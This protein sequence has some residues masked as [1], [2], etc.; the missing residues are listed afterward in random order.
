[1]SDPWDEPFDASVFDDSY[2]TSRIIAA[3]EGMDI[4]SFPWNHP[5]VKFAKWYIDKFGHGPKGSESWIDHGADYRADKGY[6]QSGETTPG[7]GSGLGDYVADRGGST[8]DAGG[9]DDTSTETETSTESTETGESTDTGDVDKEEPLMPNVTVVEEFPMD[10]MGF[11]VGDLV[12]YGGIVYALDGLGIWNKL[13]G[14]GE[15]SLVSDEGLMEEIGVTGSSGLEGLLAGVGG[16]LGVPSLS[17]LLS[18]DYFGG[19]DEGGEDNWFDKLIDLIAA[20][21]AYEEGYKYEVPTGQMASQSTVGKDWGLPSKES[22]VMQGLGPNYLEGQKYAM[23]KGAPMPA[24]THV[25]G[26]P[27][28][29]EIEGGEQGGI[30]GL[31]SH[32][33]ITPAFLEPGEFV[34]TKKATDNVGAKRLYKLMQQAEQMGMR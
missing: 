33:D 4:P 26:L 23:N 14:Q 15:S 2:E 6:A 28:V 20:K 34:F 16:L 25:G 13:P 18:G 9:G 30:M 22:M 10:D 19:G 5:A 17:D 24:A 21:D 8:T 11:S 12:Q 7:T 31:K 3:A 27:L 32:G 29:E 1:M